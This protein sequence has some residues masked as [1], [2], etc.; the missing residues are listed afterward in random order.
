M[1]HFAIRLL[2]ALSLLFSFHFSAS[3]GTLAAS[4]DRLVIGRIS[5][6]PRKHYDRLRAMADYLAEELAED[7][8]TEID[9][10]LVS[11]LEEMEAL[12]AT[13]QVDILSET[14]FMALDMVDKGL[15]EI[16]LREWKKG[17]PEYHSVIVS[18]KDG[19]VQRLED[20]AGRRIAFEDPGSTSAYLM[21]RFAL[22]DAGMTMREL[23]HPKDSVAPDEV[24]FSFANGEINV[25]SWVHR[26]RADAGAI[27]NLDWDS[28]SSTPA[29]F[30]KDLQI[31]HRTAP[32]TRS[33]FLA[34]SGLDGTLKRR[35]T[36]TLEIM[37][38]TPV[39]SAVLKKYFKVAR[40]DRLDGEAA[41]GL[42]NVRRIRQAIVSP[43]N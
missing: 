21:P 7:G 20:M 22:E 26:G 4:D 40:Y 38:E 34:R 15:A 6:E 35:I 24:G 17:V 32:V 29:H 9:V 18:R 28:E 41:E 30:K 27:S 36:E 25:I 3:S 8:I 19:P 1:L 13:G 16:L 23:S 33:L 5:N 31:V 42:E 37:H 43:T 12:L 14:P 2:I 11:E 10:V 39:G